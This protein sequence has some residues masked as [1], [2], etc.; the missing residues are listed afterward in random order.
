M[1][2]MKKYSGQKTKCPKC[3]EEGTTTWHCG[4]SSWDWECCFRKEKEHLHRCCTN[5]KYEWA[6]KCI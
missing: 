5:C 1:A 6:E 2:E 3:G 4:G